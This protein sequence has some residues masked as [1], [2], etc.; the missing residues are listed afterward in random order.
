[1]INIKLL[2]YITQYKNHF[3]LTRQLIPLAALARGVKSP[4][5][6]E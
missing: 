2:K 5:A 1:M 4:E 3:G 6:V